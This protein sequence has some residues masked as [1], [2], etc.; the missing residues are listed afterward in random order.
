MSS[1]NIFNPSF[2]AS[3][4][5]GEEE[6]SNFSLTASSFVIIASLSMNS[7]STLEYRVNVQME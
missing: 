3:G 1:S 7:S 4:I 6:D 5:E 2:L